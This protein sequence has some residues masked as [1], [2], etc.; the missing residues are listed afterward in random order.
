[1]KR[2]TQTLDQILGSLSALETTWM[3]PFAERVVATIQGMEEKAAYG[4]QDLMDLLDAD[5]EIAM[6]VF[7]LFLDKSKDELTTEIR[8]LASEMQGTSRSS[9]LQNKERFVDILDHL[10]VRQAISQAMG[11]RFTWRDLV[12]ERLKSGRGSAI[13]GQRRGRDL[14]QFVERIVH[15]VFEEGGF[16][17]GISFVG[18]D[19]RSTEKADFA[20]PSKTDP[21]ILIEV[22]AYGA[23]GSK[24][25]DVLGDVGRIIEQKRPDALFMLVTDG[26][27]WEQR[28]SD[29]SKLV[30]LQNDGV[31]Y[32]IYTKRMASDL[33]NDLSQIKNEMGLSSGE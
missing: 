3:D 19:G 14:E 25:T 12:L 5:F 9:Y 20:I 27:T 23:T 11:R 7:R 4:R 8:S 30:K 15:A 26:K 2:H 31:I 21:R 17:R 16:D 1:M 33:S 6:T 13:K 10:L 32:R 28:T 24:Q 29:L 18:R 22:K